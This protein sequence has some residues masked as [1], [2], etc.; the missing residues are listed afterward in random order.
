MEKN[1]ALQNL[2]NITNYNIGFT[3]R[4]PTDFSILFMLIKKKTNS[5]ISISS[6]KRIW[7]YVDYRSFPSPNTLNILSRFNEYY[8]WA[9]FLKENDILTEN[10]VSEY[11]ADSLIY[12]DSLTPGDVLAISWYKD[13]ACTLEYLSE[14]RFKVLDS[15]NIKLL[16][17]DEVTLHSIC[18]G[19]PICVSDIVRGDTV[20]P[21][22]IGAKNNGI[23]KITFCNRA[24]SGK[25]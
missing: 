5:S 7:G 10:D 18:V 11:L 25:E 20:I 4:T 13:K 2:V 8:D 16:A 22:Y 3:P 24:A 9:T 21:G 14:H 1:I 6:L 15:S 17:D 12:A 23:L 19:L